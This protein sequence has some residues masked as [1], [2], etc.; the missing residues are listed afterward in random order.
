MLSGYP[1]NQI[2]SSVERE[3]QLHQ[4]YLEIVGQEREAVTAIALDRCNMFGAK[5]AA[6]CDQMTQERSKRAELLRKAA[7]DSVPEKLSDFVTNY[8]SPADQRRI[9]PLIENLKILVRKVQRENQEFSRVL[10]FSLGLVTSSLS[11]L[12]SA[13]QEVQKSYTVQGIA[14]ES[15]HP[16]GDRY[17]GLLRQA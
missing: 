7:G 17:S 6:V 12:R 3:I 16:A 10:N 11:I 8:F 5:R 15:V 1:V 2:I 13:N 4:K 9:F 14:R